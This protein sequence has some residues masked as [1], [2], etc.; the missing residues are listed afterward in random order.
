[1]A[2]SHFQLE[3][4]IFPYIES[5]MD[6]NDRG[7]QV[8]LTSV[9]LTFMASGPGDSA[10]ERIESVRESI[11]SILTVTGVRRSMGS[12]TLVW[13]AITSAKVARDRRQ[14]ADNFTFVES[15]IASAAPNRYCYQL[16]HLVSQ[17]WVS[18]FA[19]ELESDVDTLRDVL[20]AIPPAQLELREWVD[21]ACLILGDAFDMIECHKK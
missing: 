5:M 7:L 19:Q 3:I 15:P 4:R 14:T 6:F 9:I 18:H 12:L 10:A 16:S 21:D 1:M 13:K 11:R 17:P 20:E 2:V 8:L